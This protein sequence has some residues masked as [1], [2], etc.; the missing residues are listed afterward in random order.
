MYIVLFSFFIYPCIC[1]PIVRTSYGALKGLTIQQEGGNHYHTFKSV[2]FMK[3]PL[4]DLRFELPQ[5]PDPWKHIRDASNYSPAC[6]TSTDRLEKIPQNMSED[7]LYLNIFT[8]EKCLRTSDC[9]V[10]IYY[11]GGGVS[12]DSAI[13]FSDEFILERYVKQD[14]VFAI[15]AYRLGIFGL[16]NFGDEKITHQNL[17][18]H[19]CLM[20]LHFI[21]NE[22]L[23]FGGDPAKVTIMGHSAGA[24]IVSTM[25]LSRSVDP[26]RKLFK[27]V[28]AMSMVPYFDIPELFYYNVHEITRRNGCDN[29]TNL[30]FKLN[31]MKRKGYHD[32][33]MSQREMENEG[34]RF[35]NFLNGPPFMEKN[36]NI[37]KLI[38]NAVPREIIFGCT[39]KEWGYKSHTN[40]NP[41]AAGNFMSFENL[42]EVAEYFDDLQAQNNS[43][44]FSIESQTTFVSIASYGK[45]IVENGGKVF[46]FQTDQEPGSNHVSDMQYFI[47]FHR[48]KNH[49]SDMD[50]V[51]SFYSQMMVN[52]TK[53]GNPSPVWEPLNISRMNYYSVQVDTENDIWPS[54]KENFHENEYKLWMY[55]ITAFDKYVS[56][57]KSHRLEF[58]LKEN[59]EIPTG[60]TPVTSIVFLSV[61]GLA[62]SVYVVFFIVKKQSRNDY[63]LLQ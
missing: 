32:L 5:K 52:F 50:I 17:A 54:M 29:S 34:L 22:V 14:I 18:F 21:H 1:D 57:Q 4:D 13:M 23:N 63:I 37:S 49:T 38:E 33:L 51:D 60:K 11:H 56:E 35:W 27:R 36:G 41:S 9:N 6:L 53:Y 24:N 26:D 7:C 45:A 30:A 47:G 10:I 2:P 25:A 61:C 3:P 46:I 8:S 62:F 28:I 40:I 59:F 12:L 55:N 58:S 42:L 16:Y 20:S 44:M 48:E 31:C 19:D 43:T 15:P 39:K